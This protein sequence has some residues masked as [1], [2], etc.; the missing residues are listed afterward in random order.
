MMS[1]VLEEGHLFFP[2]SAMWYCDKET[3][4]DQA[5]LCVGKRKEDAKNEM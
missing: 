5:A 2:N 3:A 4:E 1:A